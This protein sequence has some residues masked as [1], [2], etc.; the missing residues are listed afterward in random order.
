MLKANALRQLGITSFSSYVT[1]TT[2]F[3]SHYT[4]LVQSFTAH[5]PVRKLCNKLK[6]AAWRY[7]TNSYWH[8]TVMQ[9]KS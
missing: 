5:M 2:L 4:E 6:C 1:T 7:I 3:Y 8:V 9:C